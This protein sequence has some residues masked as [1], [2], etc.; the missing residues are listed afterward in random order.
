MLK[1]G[2]RIGHRAWQ[3]ERKE[4]KELEGKRQGLGVTGLRR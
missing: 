4:E 3:K 1:R 2:E